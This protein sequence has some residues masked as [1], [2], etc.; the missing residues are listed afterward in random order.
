[1]LPTILSRPIVNL[2]AFPDP[3]DPQVLPADPPPPADLVAETPASLAAAKQA[4]YDQ[5]L[6]AIADV[7]REQGK[8]GVQTRESVRDNLTAISAA[9]IFIDGDRKAAG[10]PCVD[11]RDLSS[12]EKHRLIKHFGVGVR[13]NRTV[14]QRLEKWAFHERCAELVTEHFSHKLKPQE[15]DLLVSIVWGAHGY[16]LGKV[17]GTVPVTPTEYA[18]ATL[19]L[20]GELE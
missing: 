14:Y 7:R 3:R 10:L 12:Q 17:D 9:Q 4:Q 20:L 13:R 8:Q 16:A 19:D 11:F 18:A 2:I 6:R 15:I 5:R 1:M